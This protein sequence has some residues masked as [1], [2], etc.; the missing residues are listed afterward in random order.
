MCARYGLTV[1]SPSIQ[2]RQGWV[3]PV[4][5]DSR[6][7]A[8]ENLVGPGGAAGEEVQGGL[9]TRAH[10]RA[11]QRAVD[12]EGRGQ[13][14][15]P[16]GQFLVVAGREPTFTGVLVRRTA[17]SPARSRTPLAVPSGP[18]TRLRQCHMP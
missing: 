1:G 6:A 7:G 2:K 17:T 4:A 12:I 5:A 14:G 16:F 10:V 8:A 11:V 18:Q 15:G 13:A 3:A 9:G